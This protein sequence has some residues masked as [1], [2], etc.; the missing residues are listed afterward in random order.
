ML[1][2]LFLPFTRFLKINCIFGL[3]ILNH[4]RPLNEV[5]TATHTGQ[6]P[7][8]RSLL[9]TGHGGVLLTGLFTMACLAR[10]LIDGT[11]HNGLVPPLSITNKEMPY[12]LAHNPILRRYFFN[13]VSLFSD[14][15][16]LCQVDIKLPIIDGHVKLQQSTSSPSPTTWNRD[17]AP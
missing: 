15:F 5:K 6:D 12:R 1:F 9:C 17:S 11:T 7:G 8:G 14:N 13:W 3:H 10:F 2:L 16:S 4:S